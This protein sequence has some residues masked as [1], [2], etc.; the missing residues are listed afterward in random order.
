MLLWGAGLALAQ[1][2][3]ATVILVSPASLSEPEAL[4]AHAKSR[5]GIDFK[6]TTAD[7]RFTLA[8]SLTDE[9]GKKVY[10][11]LDQAAALYEA[12]QVNLVVVTGGRQPADVTTEAK[13]GYEYLRERLDIPDDQLRLEVQG[14]STW[15]SLAAT[16]RFLHR[17]NVRDVVLVTDRYHARRAE[18]IAREVRDP[19]VGA[20]V[21]GP[22]AGHRHHGQI[23]GRVLR[24]FLDRGRGPADRVDRRFRRGGC[25]GR[26]GFDATSGGLSRGR[27]PVPCGRSG[28][29]RS[30]PCTTA[31]CRGPGGSGCRR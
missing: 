3:D 5:L 23:G 31:G 15:E 13:T 26:H 10:H 4:A 17:E 12:G 11:R 1:A 6:Q 9:S 16:A 30:A 29:R 2:L 24:Q 27:E 7:G 28:S 8:A 18:L 25:V 21:L 22:V 20:D 19:R 14:A